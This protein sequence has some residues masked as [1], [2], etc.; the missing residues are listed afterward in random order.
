MEEQPL[1][2]IVRWMTEE[3]MGIPGT[4]R[5]R[6]V[7]LEDAIDDVSGDWSEAAEGIDEAGGLAEF[8]KSFPEV[9]SLVDK[10][11]SMDDL[12]AAMTVEIRTWLQ[13]QPQAGYPTTRSMDELNRIVRKYWSSALFVPSIE[14]W[15]PGDEED[16][17]DDDESEE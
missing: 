17:D 14:L 6:H 1:G 9:L 4:V 13:D 10:L 8:V 7:K 2:Y 12:H 11:E 5:R 3:F 16:G 15:W